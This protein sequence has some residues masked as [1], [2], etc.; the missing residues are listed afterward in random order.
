MFKLLLYLLRLFITIVE[1]I[2]GSV[3]F[4]KDQVEP[5]GLPFTIFNNRVKPLEFL[6]TTLP[7]TP[8]QID[9]G[10]EIT[11]ISSTFHAFDVF[12]MPIMTFE[13]TPDRWRT[14]TL[15]SL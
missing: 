10:Q 1:P 2:E 5:N 13:E 12:M 11:L 14:A 15:T 4:V 7:F 6:F 3:E 8:C 9:I